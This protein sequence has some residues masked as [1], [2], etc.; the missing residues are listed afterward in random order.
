LEDFVTPRQ[1]PHSLSDAEAY[2]IVRDLVAARIEKLRAVAQ[3]KR[4]RELA[5]EE[6]QLEERRA[7]ER[8]E[9]LVALG[10]THALIKTIRWDREDRERAQR[11]VVHELRR[12]GNSDWTDDDVRDRV[13]EILD[14]L[15]TEDAEDDMRDDLDEGDEDY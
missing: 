7:R 3:E 2:A 15:Y 10:K 5:V 12:E 6:G 11:E 4:D 8:L 13:R 9:R 1:L 14:A